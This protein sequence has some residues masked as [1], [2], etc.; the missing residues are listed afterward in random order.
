MFARRTGSSWGGRVDGT[1]IMAYFELNGWVQRNLYSHCVSLWKALKASDQ[2]NIV[3]FVSS[4]CSLRR[5]WP[6]CVGR[7]KRTFLFYWCNRCS[8]GRSFSKADQHLTRVYFSFVLKHFFRQFSPLFLRASN[9]Q[10]VDKMKLLHL[11]SNSALTPL[12]WVILTQL[13]TTWPRYC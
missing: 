10:I 5:H 4:A 11:N 7:V 8:T 9:H 2:S 1:M 13:W 3:W 12:A 6:E